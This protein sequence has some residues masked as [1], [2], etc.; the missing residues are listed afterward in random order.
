MGCQAQIYEH[1]DLTHHNESSDSC[2]K[3]G[4]Y[5]QFNIRGVYSYL[6][7]EIQH[8]VDRTRMT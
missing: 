7:K 6:S 1:H 8:L 5:N 3:V 2:Q 4:V